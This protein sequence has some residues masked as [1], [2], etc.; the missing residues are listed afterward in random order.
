MKP[1]RNEPPRP[2]IVFSHA[3]GFPAGSYRL[4]FEHW[5]GAGY[6][7]QAIEKFGHD[8][9]FP[10][11]SNWPHLRDQLAQFVEAH[12]AGRQAHLVGH[13][14]GG[15]LSLLL[16]CRRPELAAS[17]VLIDSPLIAGWRAQVV[18]VGKATGLIGRYSPAKVSHRRR[19]E[20]DNLD[21]ARAH[22][23]GKSLFAR[24]HPEVLQDY[25]RAGLEV[26]AGRARLSFSREV[27]TRLYNTLPHHLG[28]LLRSHP[29]RC[30]VAYIGGTQSPEGRMAGL[31]TV[32]RLCAARISWVE[33]SH[34]IPF[35]KP[36]DTA[37][38]VLQ[39]LP[40]ALSTFEITGTAT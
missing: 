6:E 3:N 36:I 32:R 26:H 8:P 18:R 9:R 2:L 30:P 31:G 19:N 33:G 5:R 14:L 11:S 34:L 20:W 39:W 4:L 27:E 12:R 16:A 40:P 7:V 13:S 24:F 10:V 15:F 17:V 35:E 37:R 38:A 25:L 29:P 28:A 21:A 1:S 23:S 22:F